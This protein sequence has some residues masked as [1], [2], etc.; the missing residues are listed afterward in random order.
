MFPSPALRSRETK[1]AVAA[2]FIDDELHIGQEHQYPA[3]TCRWEF[4]EKDADA[5]AS[6]NFVC[7]C[8]CGEVDFIIVVVPRSEA[9]YRA[10]KWDGNRVNPT[11]T[12]SILRRGSK[13]QWHGYL[14]DGQFVN[15]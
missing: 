2:R 8:G 15:C 1:L 12:P 9:Y 13:C 10:W 14:T 3:G 11:I 7:P 4:Y 5:D 6:L